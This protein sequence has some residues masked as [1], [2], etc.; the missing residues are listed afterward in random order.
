[1]AK[2]LLGIAIGYIFSDFLD[3]LIGY[4]NETEKEGEDPE[5]PEAPSEDI[6]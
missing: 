4:S 6:T 5:T 3:D 2:V 1:M